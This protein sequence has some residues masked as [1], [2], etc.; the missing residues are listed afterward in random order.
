M[1]RGVW[2]AGAA[3]ALTSTLALAAP[4]SLLP[5]TFDDPAP[6]PAPAPRP[7]PAPGA[8]PAPSGP[9]APVVQPVPGATSPQGGL[10]VEV[11]L[12]ED[13]PSLAE[14][15]AMDPDEVDELLGIKPKFDIP[16]AARR[17][18]RE[19][20]VIAEGEGGFP[21]GSLDDQPPQLIRAALAANRGP[22]V[23][24][25]GH[26]LLRRALASRLDAP[27]G[28]D[29]VAFAALRAA[30]LN[31]LGEGNA[32]RAL[33]QDVDSAN[34]NT[35]LANAAF[36]AYLMTGDVLGMCP[37]ARLKSTLREDGEWNMVRAICAAYAG[38]ARQAER[39]LQR[40]LYYGEA[41]RID[42]L[43]A[44]RYAGAAGE[45]RRAVNVEWNDVDELTPWRFALSRALGVELPAGLRD[46]AG[47]RYDIGDVLIPAVPLQ[48]RVAAADR[49]AARGVISSAAMVDLYSQLWAEEIAGDERAR[50]VTLREAYVAQDAAARLGAMRELWGDGTDYG[51]QVLTAYAAARLPVD[52]ALIA[53]AP[54]IVASMLAAGLDRNAMRW[55]QAV[56]EGSEAW[57]LLAL[58]QPDRRTQVSSGAVQDF[59]DEDGSVD[60]R[61]SRFLVAGLAGLGRL[62]MDTAT[63]LASRLG[64]NLTRASVWSQR[65]DRAAE[66]G[67]PTLV[68]LLA[69]LGM[70]GDGWDK[71]TARHLF[72][73]VRSLRQVG[74][75]NEARM[76]A[77]EAVARG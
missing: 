8:A 23:S 56:P 73:I 1:R 67:N 66:L 33:V 19:I 61:K 69:G 7:A 55:G 47:I 51:R 41:P 29:P 6:A 39:E 42:A 38:E 5:D 43:L 13:F 49:A 57:A 53:D 64:V 26:I 32:A 27:R 74:L 60:Q 2:L 76:I 58:A 65:I 35:A 63:N 52:E 45:G 25:W 4:E 77:A 37:V 21:V 46:D 12:P 62:E 75:E 36:D 34:Y 44:Q 24:R 17:A 48:E 72:H 31:R 70:Q 30:L 18:V 16:P 54:R 15:E 14:L 3:L 20:G 50:A 40:I 10:D 28:M 11:T 68:A 71:M 22:L 59:M 9:S